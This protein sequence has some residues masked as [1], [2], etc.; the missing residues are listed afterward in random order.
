MNLVQ[1][2]VNFLIKH[3]FRIICRV[4]DS[5]LG[6]VPKT[7]PLILAANHINAIEV[8][9]VFTHLQPRPITGMAK[10]E[11]W[12][13]PFKGWLFSLWGAIP[14]ERGT[15]DLSAFRKSLE[16]LS[17]GRILAIAPEG[18]R[19][20]DGQLGPGNTG[21]I[22]LAVRSQAPVLP[23]V[24]YGHEN[25]W[26]NLKHLRRTDIHIAVG[27]PFNVDPSALDRE[28]RHQAVGEIMYQLAQL[29]PSEYRGVYADL[30]KAT[31]DYIHFLPVGIN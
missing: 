3:F 20:Y 21:I 19:S 11:T 16:A 9:V 28:A 25:F 30:G 12:D 4:D 7:G 31:T 22:M 1:A 18:T 2:I 5:Q 17:A 8:P 14:V 27:R 26:E 13:N 10:I 23:M 29:L 24:F 15:A 6:R